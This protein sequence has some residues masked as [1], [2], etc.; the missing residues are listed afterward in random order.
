MTRTSDAT[1]S[2]G[3]GVADP[4]ATS[5]SR[6]G[7]TG[8]AAAGLEQLPGRRRD[9]RGE[10]GLPH[11]PGVDPGCARTALGDRPHD[12]ALAAAHVAAGEDARLV[13][14][15]HGIALDVAARI[16]VDAELLEQALLLRAE[17]T[18]RQEHQLHGQLEVGALD[19]LELAVD[20]LHLV[21]TQRAHVAVVVG[22]EALGVDAVDTVATLLVGRRH[23]EHV[24][25]RRPRV[26]GGA[27]LGRP[28]Q[29][30]EL[31]HRCGALAVRCAQAVGAGV[32]AADDDDVLALGGDRR[33]V[34]VALLHPVAPG[35]EFHR[36]V[37]AGVLA[38][39]DREVTP[40][41][42]AAH[43]HDGVELLSQLR[44]GDIDTDVDVR[45][46]LGA[47]GS[48]LREP[49]FEVTLLHL[50]LGDA[51]AQQAT[52]AVGALE[53]HD[54]VARTRQLLR[55]GEPGGARAD[56]RRLAPRLHLGDDGR[57]PALGPRP[58]DDL[59]LD[60]LD[61]DRVLVDAEHARG[62]TRGGAQA[63][64]ELREVVGGVQALDGVAPVVAVDEVVP[65]RDEVPERAA[66]VAERDAAVHAA[67]GLELEGLGR[68]RLVDLLPIAQPHRH[69]PA[70]G[71]LR[72]TTSGTRSSHPREDSITL[73]SVS[74]CDKPRRS[75]SRIT[76]STRR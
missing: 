45:P 10:E 57:D 15:E 21:G 69:R 31:V 2:S 37:D 76:A 27:G 52:D 41:G 16:E 53:H 23:A 72:A 49:A 17:K 60:L 22:K 34:E 26:G 28:R 12:E 19:L 25:P 24:R 46:E 75:A 3:L 47:L 43:E 36:L 59:D 42:G 32:A 20:H 29:D 61:G 51:V 9:R 35:Q 39:R 8:W 62:L 55:G 50:E 13:G 44:D 38:A 5:L 64:G 56:D 74:S 40:R 14:H 18:H 66:V 30:L 48:H 33:H 7:R 54:V 58:L 73:T 70:G 63:T 68:E 1:W 65:V 67:A 4:S 6:S 11:Q 71:R